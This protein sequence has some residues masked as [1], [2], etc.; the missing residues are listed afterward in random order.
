VTGDTVTIAVLGWLFSRCI[1]LMP[2][3]EPA[4]KVNWNPMTEMV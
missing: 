1:P 4:L 2:A 3:A